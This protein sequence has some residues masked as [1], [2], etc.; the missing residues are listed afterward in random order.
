M[1]SGRT[2]VAGV[3]GSPI[4]HSLSPLLHNAWLGEAGVD[5]V[6]VAFESTPERFGAFARG[7]RGGAIRGLNVTAPFKEAALALADLASDAARQAGS[8]N[9]LVF[10]ADGT[11]EADNTDGVGLLAAFAEGAPGFDPR[12]GPVVIFGAGGA[13]RGAAVGFLQAGAPKVVFVNRNA[14]RAAGLAQLFG[15]RALSFAET[16]ATAAVEGAQAVVNATPLGLNGSPGPAIPIDRLDPGCVVMDMIYRPV[17]TGLLE[18]A[19]ARGLRTA[20]GLAMLIGQGRPSFEAFFGRPTPP[21]DVRV[22]ALR[23]LETAS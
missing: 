14:E 11:I 18:A 5:A 4:R 7:L 21:L 12:R 2:L 16:E 1:I 15:D 20:D 6:Y 23:A 13:A 9:V 10:H 22:L 17:R 8:A 3:V 19:A